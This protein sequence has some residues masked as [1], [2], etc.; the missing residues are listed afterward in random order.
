M[1][2]S[3]QTCCFTVY[4]IQELLLGGARVAS[5]S[6]VRTATILILLMVRNE[7][8]QKWDNFRASYNGHETYLSRET[9]M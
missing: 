9:D 1:D 2:F 8:V 3:R 6:E 5:N 4:K 7:K